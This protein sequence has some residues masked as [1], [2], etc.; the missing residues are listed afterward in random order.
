EELSRGPVCA[1]V[2]LNGNSIVHSPGWPNGY[3]K[4]ATCW[5]Y[6]S[7]S[8]KKIIELS[9]DYFKLNDDDYLSIRDGAFQN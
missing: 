3:R 6:L 2:T 8:P 9:M 5:Y 4:N 1:P 7:A